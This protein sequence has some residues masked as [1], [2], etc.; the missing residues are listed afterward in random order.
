VVPEL[1]PEVVPE[2]SV[3]VPEVVPE[4]CVPRGARSGARTFGL[5]ART[6]A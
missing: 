6:F 3:M 4:L 5:G 1:V 2:L